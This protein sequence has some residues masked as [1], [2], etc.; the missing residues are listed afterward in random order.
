MIWFREFLYFRERFPN[1]DTKE[2]DETDST[3][4]R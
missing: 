3:K 2:K 1:H 4:E